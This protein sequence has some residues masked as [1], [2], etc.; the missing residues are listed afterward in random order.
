MVLTVKVYIL[1]L[2]PT[3]MYIN[4]AYS[5]HLVSSAISDIIIL[6]LGDGGAHSI[7]YQRR[8]H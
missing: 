6:E 2:Q 5:R 7:M 3:L 4:N 1:E 8:P